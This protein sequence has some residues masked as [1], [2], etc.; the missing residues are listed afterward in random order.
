M[1]ERPRLRASKPATHVVSK[2]LRKM[3][4]PFP[5]ACGEV[6]VRNLPRK[7][8]R[9]VSNFSLGPTWQTSHQNLVARKRNYAINRAK[10]LKMQ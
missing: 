1:Q 4:P 3:S 9:K 7:D 6:L 10:K 8:M 5:L 2:E